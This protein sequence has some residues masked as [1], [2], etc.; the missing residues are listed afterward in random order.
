MMYRYNPVNKTWTRT[1]TNFLNN[2]SFKYICG[3]SAVIFNNMMYL[4][5]GKNYKTGG[6]LSGL[7]C[8]NLQSYNWK[9]QELKGYSPGAREHAALV[10]HQRSSIILY[11]GK[12][13]QHI[14]NDFHIY[15]IQN[16][17]WVQLDEATYDI[18]ISARLK[19][20]L[21]S[22]QDNLYLFGGQGFTSQGEP[23]LLN[24][25]YQ[26]KLLFRPMSTRPDLWVREIITNCGPTQ[27]IAQFINIPNN[28][29]YLLLWGG[30]N[31]VGGV[32]Q[33]DSGYWLYSVSDVTWIWVRL[34][35][36]F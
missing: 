10:L 33:G 1:V 21:C 35:Q 12:N 27:R 11:G 30:Q 25:F 32:R 23:I 28:D 36:N 34:R 6:Y 13:G 2:N 4:F 16:K 9:K 24:D 20:T 14:L 7:W 29:N 3:H 18:K 26:L 17:M 19:P 31:S 5:G 8:L 15:R 22:L